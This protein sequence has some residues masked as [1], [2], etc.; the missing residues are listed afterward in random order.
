MMGEYD[1]LE[2]LEEKRKIDDEWYSIQEISKGLEKKGLSNGLTGSLWRNL[3]KLTLHNMI[4]CKTENSP[5]LWHN[6]KLFRAVRK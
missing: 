1:I 2:L 3:T 6:K 4:E 5:G